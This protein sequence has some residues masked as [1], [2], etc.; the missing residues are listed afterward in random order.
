MIPP[1][2]FI[3]RSVN[4]DAWLAARR[5]GVTATAVAEAATPAGFAKV[6]E[7][8]RNPT[9]VTPNEFMLFGTDSERELMRHAHRVHGILP[10]DWLIAGE[11]RRHLA[12]PDGL[13]LD[14]TVIAECKTTGK[15]WA[16]VPIKYRRQVQ[17]QLAITGAERCLFVW[18]LRVP[19]DQGWFFLGWVE[20]KTLWVERDEDEISKL[21]EVADRL[22]EAKAE[23]SDGWEA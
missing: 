11:D 20:P 13:S 22:I 19:D 6:V 12:T 21:V 3:E 7:E 4:Y 2:R 14:H 15:D 1:D 23:V 18:N 16:T 5:L 9:V 8:F 10:S 17:W